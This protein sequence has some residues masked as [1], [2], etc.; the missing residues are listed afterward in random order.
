MNF[1]D[2]IIA[3]IFSAN[4][5]IMKINTLFIFCCLLMLS[6]C[7]EEPEIPDLE[8]DAVVDS[9][10]GDWVPNRGGMAFFRNRGQGAAQLLLVNSKNR[11]LANYLF[12]G[13][14]DSTFTFEEPRAFLKEEL[15]PEFL[16]FSEYAINNESPFWKS[17]L[18]QRQ[19]FKL[20]VTEVYESNQK[21]YAAGGFKFVACNP[22]LFP[23]CITVSGHFRNARVFDDQVSLSNYVYLTD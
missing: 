13:V 9:T 1:N 14:S 16:F 4:I 11:K 10:S 3:L 6:S 15:G 20:D 23:G 7:K 8:F 19:A 18:T 17:N 21:L 22:E 5:H 2:L 12:M